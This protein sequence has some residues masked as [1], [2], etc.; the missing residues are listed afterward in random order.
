MRLKSTL[1]GLL[2]L[3]LFVAALLLS[4]IIAMGL[5]FIAALVPGFSVFSRTNAKGSWNIASYHSPHSL[6]WRWLL[7]FSLPRSRDESR[8]LG[9]WWYPTNT[10]LQFGFQIARCSFHVSTQ[11]PVW[12]RDL[13]QRA[14]GER[15]FDEGNYVERLA[16]DEF[17]DGVSAGAA[18]RQ[19]CRSLGATGTATSLKRMLEDM[20]ADANRASFDRSMIP[21]AF[22]RVDPVAANEARMESFRRINDLADDPPR[23]ASAMPHMVTIQ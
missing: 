3:P 8:W 15:D 6:T 7:N 20:L 18:A 11:R 23:A 17:R 16:R 1:L 22:E 5:I 2:C 19:L 12:Y 21:S 4:P 13:Y 14:R 10:G 9:F